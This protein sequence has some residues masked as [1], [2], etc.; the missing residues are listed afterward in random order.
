[1]K[2]YYGSEAVRA[3]DK[4]AAE[5][6]CVSGEVLMENAGR[7]AAEIIAARYPDA[8]S[9]LAL[10]GPGNNG[11]DGFVAARHLDVMGR[12]A[13][14]ISVR[15]TSEYTGE[16]RFAAIA[17]ERCGIKIS[18]SRDMSDAAI[19]DALESSVVVDALLGVG[20][21]GEP[22]GEVKRLIEMS[23]GLGAGAVS[24]DI[25]SGVGPDTGEVG[26]VSFL[27][28][29]T[30]SFLALKPAHAIAPGALMC[31]ET[32]TAGIG[33]KPELALDAAPELTG[34]DASDIPAMFPRR[35]KNIHKGS[36]GSLLVV[37]GSSNFR[38]APVLS[39]LAALK[40]GCGP[41]ALAAPASVIA[42]AAS[43]LPEAIFIPLPED[44]GHV[45][46]AG[47]EEA[48]FPFA[49]KFDTLVLGPGF[50]L[51]DDA[52][53]VSRF[54]CGAW[55]KPMLVDADAL[56]AGYEI[57]LDNAV[58]TPHA[59]EASFIL[60]VPPAEVEKH[61]LRSC[62]KLAEKFGVAILKG[63]RTLISDGLKTNVALEGGP[64]LAVPGSGDV[65]SGVVGAFLAAGLKP[66]DAATLGAVVHGAAGERLAASRGVNGVLARDI[67]GAMREV[68]LFKET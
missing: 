41:V 26:A 63:P 54:L 43:L 6:L 24:L 19:R 8:G 18:V 46:F 1:M 23:E 51:S 42:S 40:A 16:A 56:K 28:D 47:F 32:V 20:A 68:A 4:K 39:S 57:R 60:G 27:A 66:L 67:A 38:G 17:A 49:D 34:Y 55:R 44:D 45:R 15:N 37:G 30:V 35:G 48:L 61:R 65:L 13:E 52:M 59:G 2:Y 9:F 21:S 29:L 64:E 31:G 10:C 53:K 33:V 14:I 58:A 5:A 12:K 25:P 62:R 50:G 36:R 3:A 7:A 11:G 22:R